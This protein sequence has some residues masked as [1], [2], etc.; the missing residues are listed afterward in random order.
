[1]AAWPYSPCQSLLPH[2]HHNGTRQPPAA[3]TCVVPL[4]LT[5]TI[6][7]QENSYISE[8]EK[9]LTSALAPGGYECVAGH[10]LRAIHLVLFAGRRFRRQ[11]V[12]IHGSAVATGIGNLVGN[13][14]RRTTGWQADG[15]G[16]SLVWSVVLQLVGAG[17]LRTAVA[18]WQQQRHV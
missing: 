16:T 10:S 13:K 7:S 1:M 15:P 11:V 18:H 5:T 8:W 14:V 12:A 3:V 4:P 6:T 2:A 17:L 9:L